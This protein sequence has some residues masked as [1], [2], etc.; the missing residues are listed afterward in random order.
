MSYFIRTG[1]FALRT[2]FEGVF[3]YLEFHVGEVGRMVSEPEVHDD[4]SSVVHDDPIGE[5]PD[6]FELVLIRETIEG[7]S[8]FPNDFPEVIFAVVD[9][10]QFRD[11]VIEF[12]FPAVQSFEFPFQRLECFLFHLFLEVA[13]AKVDVLIEVLES[14]RV[15]FGL[16]GQVGEL[17]GV[18]VDAVV[19]FP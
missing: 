8:V 15:F 2:L 6:E 9:P 12:G 11:P 16:L 5:F 14:V 4:F 19:A 10:F 3:A 7:L 18:I 13:L 17:L 1:Q